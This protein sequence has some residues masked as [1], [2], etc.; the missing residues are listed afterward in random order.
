[1]F[2]FRVFFLLSWLQFNIFSLTISCQ[3][4]VSS[5]SKMIIL[6]F[7]EVVLTAN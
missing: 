5:L 6:K 1:M 7:T 4:I 3:L 2:E